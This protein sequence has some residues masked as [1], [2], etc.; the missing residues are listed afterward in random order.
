MSRRLEWLASGLRRAFIS[1]MALG[2]P[3]AAAAS[4]PSLGA[5]L[6]QAL[7]APALRGA[8][9]A[10]LAVAQDGSVLFEHNADL[11]L[12]PASN[13]KVLTA[14]AALHAFGP[15]HRFQTRVMANAAPDESGSVTTLYV[16]GGG[17]PALTS[18]DLWRLA[19]D[20]R[21]AGVRR[22]TGDIVLDDTLFD[23][24]RWHPS[25]G[26]TGARAYHAPVGA[27]TVNYGAFTVSVLPG[28]KAGVPARVTLDPPVSYL[29]LTNRART[30]ATR[31]R[32]SLKFDRAP[33]GDRESV[34]IGGGIRVGRPQKN[35]YRSVLD[36]TRYAGAVL[37]LQLE[38]IG[39]GVDGV[40]RA[41]HVPE[42]AERLLTFEGRAL[43]EIVNRFMKYSNNQIGES[44]VKGLGHLRT[45]QAG[46]WNNGLAAMREGLRSLGL[47]LD[48]VALRDGSGLSYENRVSPRLFVAALRTAEQ[49]FRFGPEF[50]ASL[51]IASR[52]G[53]LSDRAASAVDQ[54]RA[55][56]GLLT[57]ITGLSGYAQRPD[58]SRVTFSVLVNGF[59]R[60]ADQA[61]RGVDGFVAE[62]VTP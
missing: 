21:R 56:T 11:A 9:I 26:K 17:D 61:M 15:T 38:A 2:L 3:L 35:L 57:R 14:M 59:R 60:S 55:K 12:V 46:T 10:A 54:V 49:N 24:V 13:Q 8:E 62:L 7:E 6:A 39:I 30:G 48:G 34:V 37:K 18:E 36:P 45:G 52:D 19:V 43:S 32:M 23:R 51:P 28:E 1:A 25:W 40:T 41:G 33:S 16:K 47:P 27:L 5:R 20:L 50:R 53:T 4:G 29:K 44:L 58:G 42:D 31:A 22:V